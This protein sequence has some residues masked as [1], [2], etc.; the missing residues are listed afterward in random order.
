MVV[1]FW[2]L[3]ARSMIWRDEKSAF[4]NN[5]TLAL[6]EGICEHRGMGFGWGGGTIMS[7]D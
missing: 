5:N 2:I 3:D 1:V 4:Y 6:T 7:G